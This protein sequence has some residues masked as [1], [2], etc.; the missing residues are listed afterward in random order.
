[1]ADWLIADPLVAVDVAA[2]RGRNGTGAAG[3]ALAATELAPR[4]RRHAERM[5]GDASEDIVCYAVLSCLDGVTW[6]AVA[7]RV[8]RLAEMAEDLDAITEREATM[9]RE[10]VEYDDRPLLWAMA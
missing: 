9:A 8:L 1:M 10:R 7:L 4:L 6:F 2:A 5:A 3:D